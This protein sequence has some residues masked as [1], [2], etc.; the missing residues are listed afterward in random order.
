MKKTAI[1]LVLV[2]TFLV[3]LSVLAFSAG[4][5]E[6]DPVVSQSYLEEV[7]QKNLLEGLEKE[8]KTASAHTRAEL[9]RQLGQRVA[10]VQ[11]DKDRS[12]SVARRQFGRVTLKLGDTLTLKQ[13]CRVTVYSGSIGALDSLADITLG[14]AVSKETTPTLTAGHTFM[15]KTNS[16]AQMEVLSP[17]A[18]VFLNGVVQIRYSQNTDYGALANA[19]NTLGLFQG[20]ADGTYALDGETTRAQGLVMFLRLTG[21]EDEA[22]ACEDKSPFK[23]VPDDHWA[24][25]YVVYAYQKGLTNGTG[26][27]TF[28]PNQAVT[29][30]HY[31]TFLMRA[32]QYEEGAQFA[33]ATVLQDA[34][35]AGLFSLEEIQVINEGKLQRYK[36]VYLSYY[37]LYCMEQKSNVML[38][39][40]LIADGTVTETDLYKAMSKVRSQRIK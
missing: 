22:L 23:D 14:E 20:M 16:T 13:G 15:Q 1:C 2:L 25:P 38:I 4:G 17:T 6:T 21:M 8:V 31:L 9:I 35:N 24:R 3:G 12:S 34:I 28:S 10:K 36:M 33:Y 27:D 29:A 5:D 11:L 7:W 37:G 39:D 30:H 26:A 19:L 18:E 32:L 40:K